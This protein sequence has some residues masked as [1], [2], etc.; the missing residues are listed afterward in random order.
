M[1]FLILSDVVSRSANPG[2]QID[3]PL[4]SKKLRMEW[5]TLKLFLSCG[6]ASWVEPID[7]SDLGLIKRHWQNECKRSVAN[8]DEDDHDDDD[9]DDD[10]YD[11]GN[12]DDD[13]NNNK[14]IITTQ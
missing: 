5:S 14:S 3:L 10:D 2:P 11:G 7:Q 13:D 12:D 1:V 8:D 6:L 9:D 4:G